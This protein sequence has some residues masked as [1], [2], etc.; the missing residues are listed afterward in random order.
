MSILDAPERAAGRHTRGTIR[1]RPQTTRIKPSH[2]HLDLNPSRR[3][4]VRSPP[5]STPY[6]ERRLELRSRL[7]IGVVAMDELQHR[8]DRP[9]EVSSLQPAPVL[10]RRGHR[11]L[12]HE[13]SKSVTP[14][15]WGNQLV[16][17]P[18]IGI[19]CRAHRERIEARVRASGWH[20]RLLEEQN[21]H[22]HTRWRVWNRTAKTDDHM[23]EGNH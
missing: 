20:S 10:P 5:F 18:K 1:T 23:D 15:F 17:G 21:Q 7:V 12:L 11:L 14:Q 6:L 19:N 13:P 3:G 22:V 2:A 4:L 9:Y 16:P 8:T